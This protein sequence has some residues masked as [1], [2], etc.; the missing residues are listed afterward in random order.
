MLVGVLTVEVMNPA[1]ELVGRRAGI[2]DVRIR[3]G[4]VRVV[5]QVEELSAHRKFRGLQLRNCK[6]L[7]YG[8]IC[9][10]VGR[11]SGLVTFLLPKGCWRRVVGCTYNAARVAPAPSFAY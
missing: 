4:K 6:A 3:A 5:E 10:S 7:Q 11:C 1:V 2:A 8:Q 9:V